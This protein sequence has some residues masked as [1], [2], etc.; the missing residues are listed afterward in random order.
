[1]NY[2]IERECER[3]K[4]SLELSIQDLEKSVVDCLKRR[5]AQ[6]DAKLKSYARVIST[7]ASPPLSPPAY[8][9]RPHQNPNLPD[10]V[11]DVFYRPPVKAEFLNLILRTL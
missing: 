11:N 2:K 5:D 4:Q 1:M 9:A 6:I 3:V 7:P 10:N 8:H